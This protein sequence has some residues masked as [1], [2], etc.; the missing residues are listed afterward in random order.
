MPE[1]TIIR[2]RKSDRLAI[3]FGSL[4]A[5]A[6]GTLAVIATVLIILLLVVVGEVS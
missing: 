4:E 6:N 3:R 5:S 1:N 2:K